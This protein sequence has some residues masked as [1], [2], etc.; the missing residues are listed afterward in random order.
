M[1]SLNVLHGKELSYLYLCRAIFHA[2]AADGIGLSF[3][4]NCINTFKR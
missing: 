1:N 3:F 4:S 2:F